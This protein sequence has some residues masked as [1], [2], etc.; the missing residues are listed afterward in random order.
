MT[1]IQIGDKKLIIEDGCNVEVGADEVRV[2]PALPA[3]QWIPPLPIF[4]PQIPSLPYLPIY[5]QPWPR[6][7]TGGTATP[8]YQGN[9]W[10]GQTGNYN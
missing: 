4:I 7:D 10:I 1:T 5:P 2:K 9:T 8:W 3:I 6:P